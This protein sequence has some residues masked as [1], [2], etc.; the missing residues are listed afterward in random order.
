MNLALERAHPLQAALLEKI[1]IV[2]LIDHDQD[3]YAMILDF[4]SGVR[5]QSEYCCIFSST[6]YARVSFVSS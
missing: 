1:V 4:M 5:I 2:V 3:K 6:N